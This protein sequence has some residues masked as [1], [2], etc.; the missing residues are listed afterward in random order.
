MTD[1]IRV[2]IV[3][4]PEAEPSVVA[5]AHDALWASGVL[6]N[7]ISGIPEA[8]V[9]APELV[10]LDRGMVQTATGIKLQ[11]DRSIADGPAGDILLVPTLLMASGRAFG[12]ANPELVNWVRQASESGSHVMSICTGAFLLAEAGLLDHCDATTHWAFAAQFRKEYPRVNLLA[13]RVLVAARP[14][15]SI[16]TCGGAA[17]WMDMVLYMVGRHAGAEA[18]MHLAK[19]QMYD[20]HHQGQTPYC[21]LTT[22]PQLAD[23]LIHDCQEWLADHYHDPDPVMHMIENCGLSRRTFGRRFHSATGYAPLDYV[24][25]VRIEEAKQ[26]LETS[27]HSIEKVGEMVGYEDPVS[28]R[29][30]FKRHVGETPAVY[31]RRQ[32]VSDAAKAIARLS[33]ARQPAGNDMTIPA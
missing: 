11:T 25:R 4:P 16:V 24:Q 6:W 5:G 14:D 32:S 3:V 10:G 12:R 27:Q 19:V 23:K 22:R 2:S 13:D 15:G 18:A 1:L 9:F 20:W 8:P 31:R 21:R 33:T 28:F 17:S 29:R 26:M 7:R 30:L